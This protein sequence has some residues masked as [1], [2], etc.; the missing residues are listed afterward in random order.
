MG[1]RLYVKLALVGLYVHLFVLVSL[2]ISVIGT[3]S[4][5]GILLVALLEREAK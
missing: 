4:T 3:L 2:G 1:H 5:I